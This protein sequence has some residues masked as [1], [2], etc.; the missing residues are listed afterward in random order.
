MP[1]IDMSQF[2]QNPF[3]AIVGQGGGMGQG[4][5]QQM[6]PQGQPQPQ[7]PQGQPQGAGAEMQPPTPEDQFQYGKNPDSSRSIISAIQALEKYISE[8]TDR[9][10][11]QTARGIIMLL[12]RLMQKDQQKYGQF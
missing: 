5:P 2:D 12:G 9:D 1:Q 10:E 11:I 3:E 7:Q 6:P 8:S 4:M